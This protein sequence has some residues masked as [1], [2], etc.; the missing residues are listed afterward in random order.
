MSIDNKS[1]KTDEIIHKFIDLLDD[2][3]N[4]KSLDKKPE[5][6][7]DDDDINNFRIKIEF[8]SYLA[9]AKRRSVELITSLAFIV[10]FVST[11]IQ[12]ILANS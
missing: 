3:R 5:I 11:V 12:I 8:E 10:G 7:D 9:R 6:N 1:K 2:R 4:V